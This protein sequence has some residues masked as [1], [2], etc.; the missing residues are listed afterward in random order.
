MTSSN[1]QYTCILLLFTISKCFFAFFKL[2]L[3]CRLIFQSLK[4]ILK[5]HDFGKK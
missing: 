2:A 1:N 5:K 4:I 3:Q